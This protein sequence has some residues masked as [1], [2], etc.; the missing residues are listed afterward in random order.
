MNQFRE[1]LEQFMYGRHGMDELGRYLFFLY[2]VCFVCNLLTK[3]TIFYLLSIFTIL[4]MFFRVLSKNLEARQKENAIFLQRTNKIQKKVRL[5][6]RMWTD[7]HTHVYRKCPHCK[8]MLRLPKKKG[9]HT[10]SCPK[11]HSDFEVKG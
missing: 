4:Y 1:K 6:K 9:K 3:D 2:I 8:T 10:V 5:W 11:C 7:R